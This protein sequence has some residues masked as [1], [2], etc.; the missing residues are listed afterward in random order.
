M[1]PTPGGSA[2]RADVIVT[3]EDG[4]QVHV[5]VETDGDHTTVPHVA[6]RPDAYAT[7]GP[8]FVP[9]DIVGPNTYTVRT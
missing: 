5:Q 8:P 2:M 7:W 3:L 9:S 6:S 4:R 1:P